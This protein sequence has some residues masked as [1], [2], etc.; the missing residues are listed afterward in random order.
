MDSRSLLTR[1]VTSLRADGVIKINVPNSF[2]YLRKLKRTRDFSSLSQNSIMPIA[3]LGHVNSFDYQSLVVLGKMVGLQPLRPRF[4]NLYNGSSGWIDIKNFLRLI[5]RPFYRHIFPKSTY[6]YFV[7][8]QNSDTK[9]QT[10][11]RIA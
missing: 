9:E 3:P 2:S 8:D 4:R 10:D 6:V 7:L 11:S 5:F 1:L